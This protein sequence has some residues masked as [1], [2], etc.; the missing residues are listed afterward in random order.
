MGA[1]EESIDFDFEI[2]DIFKGPL[3]F[4]QN[5]KDANEQQI[6]QILL[7][8]MVQYIPDLQEDSNFTLKN[9]K[10]FLSNYW[11]AYHPQF[12]VLHKPS[13]STPD[14][15]PL[16]LLSMALIGSSLC[17][18][19]PAPGYWDLIDS[20]TIVEL[21]DKIARP[22]RWL[23]L[24]CPEA[25]PPCKSWLIHSLL[26]LEMYEINRS[27]RD[28]HERAC[29]YSA[30]K[31]QLLRRSPFLGD[32]NAKSSL[33]NWIEN[34]SM[35]RVAWE[36]FYVDTI[37]AV[38]FNHPANLYAN[39]LKLSLP[40]PDEFWETDSSDALDLSPS[41]LIQIPT[42]SES[43]R[44]ILQNEHVS[45]GYFGYKI[46]LAG[47][48]NL[49][50][51]MEQTESQSLVLG[52]KLSEDNNWQ[53]LIASALEYWKLSAPKTS[54]LCSDKLCQYPEY[55][56]AQT[57]LRIR[58]YDYYVYAGSPHRANVKI[59]MKDYESAA[60]RISRWAQSL[61]GALTVVQAYILLFEM[62]VPL[63]SNSNQQVMVEYEPQ[64]DPVIYRP[65]AVLATIFPLWCYVFN[66]YGPE[67]SFKAPDTGLQLEDGFTPSVEDPGSYLRRIREEFGV[68]TGKPVNSL[69]S[70]GSEMV[71]STLAEYAKAL[72]E[73]PKINN[74]VGLLVLL[75]RGYS[76][77]SS[78]VA[79]RFGT[80]I[81]H[82]SDRS[83]GS[84]SV[85]CVELNLM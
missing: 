69:S 72:P 82:C 75:A 73:I 27:T 40:C 37:Q 77:S 60:K 8:Q 28:L 62:I 30:T 79:K 31:I 9:M 64:K 76:K 61:N 39:N 81:K 10:L 49:I 71:T 20:D 74:I 12:P 65:M 45:T 3:P 29:I 11:S 84:N 13:F 50:L 56:A 63:N 83:M 1:F 2:P 26:I 18:S 25:A 58:Q 36:A 21:S 42:I 22:L 7:S 6:D 16:L 57:Y 44:K 68:R 51:Q 80:L 32:Q 5:S 41:S 43:L 46:I 48:L 53:E 33:E 47:L 52:L 85:F 54:N 70:M 67:S 38:V 17:Q 55:H 59:N 35:R 14:A 4:S 34:E 19:A 24:S 15:H 23:L 78:Q 66:L